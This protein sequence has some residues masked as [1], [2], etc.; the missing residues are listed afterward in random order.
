M[1]FHHQPVFAR[2]L[3]DRALPAPPG[4]RSWNGSD[5]DGRFAVHR[6]N[7]VS[8]LIEALASTFPVIAEL[9]G[10]SFFRA[11]ARQF[12]RECPPSGP[13][14]VLY[15][16]RFADFIDGHEPAASLPYLADV[17]R[18]EFARVQAYHSAD[19]APVDRA[20]IDHALSCGEKMAE[21]AFDLHPSLAVVDSR[22]AIASIWA[23]HQGDADAALR[24]VDPLLAETAIVLRMNL[25]VLVL[26]TTAAAGRFVEALQRGHSLGQSAAV[27][28][29]ADPTFDLAES[30]G[31][32]FKHATITSICLPK[33]CQP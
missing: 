8:S 30:L 28:A 25:D 21:L 24:R 18:L 7:V 31:L 32:L 27:A 19:V 2:A 3:L 26:P 14:L 22:F 4:L 13:V 9:V 12:V 33:G 17:A 23:A 29:E 1:V 11:M 20:V 16:N 15:G 10:E 6:N 5:V